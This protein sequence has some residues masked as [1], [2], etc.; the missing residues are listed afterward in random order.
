MDKCTQCGKT[1]TPIELRIDQCNHCFPF[2][3]MEQLDEHHTEQGALA[4]M[5]SMQ[6]A[7]Q[8]RFGYEI[9]SMSPEERTKMI[10]EYYIQLD[11]ELQEMLYEL[12]FFK[13]W[14]DYSGITPD[15]INTSWHSAKE[16]FIDAFHFMLTIAL[17]LGF[18]ETELFGMYKA[19]NKENHA[20]QD[21]GY[22][23]DVS[24]R[25]QVK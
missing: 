19:K 2:A 21:R 7:L 14:K 23:H 10:K 6:Y 11:A 16:E 25:K 13:L 20:R 17:S 22:T 24:Y 12:P 9:D 18:D 4:T 15:E 3:S 8:Q 1:L 5:L